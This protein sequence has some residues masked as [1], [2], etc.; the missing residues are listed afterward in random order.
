MAEKIYKGKNLRIHIGGK[1]VF[2]AT[3]CTFTTSLE[4]ESIATK[5]TNGKKSTPGAYEWSLST[6]MLLNNKASD[7]TDKLST[8]EL[9]AAYTA[10]QLVAVEFTTK[11]LGDF[12]ISGNAYIASLDMSAPVSGAATGSTSFT[13]DGDF[14][15]SDVEA[16]GEGDLEE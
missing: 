16:P 1:V 11:E 5:D 12:I 14:I 8:K 10:K 3:D 9:V 6:N 13:G 2:H 15:L 7:M 4:L